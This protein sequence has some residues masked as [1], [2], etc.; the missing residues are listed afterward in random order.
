MNPGVL[1]YIG[2]FLVAIGVLVVVHELGHYCAA[3]L[4]NVKVLRFSVGF[5][6]TLFSR[7]LGP[8]QTEWSIAAFP[9]GGYVKMLDEGEAPVAEAEL[10]RAFNRQPVAKRA[11]IV[12]AGPLS[13]LLMAVA[14]YWV[15]HLIGIQEMRPLIGNPP[16]GSVAAEA[17]FL[18]GQLI[19]QVQG[20]SV[21]TWSDVRSEMLEP[22]LSHEP[23]EMIVG[24]GDATQRKVLPTSSL[25]EKDFESDLLERLGLTP[26][27][28][29]IRAVVGK[30]IDGSPAA[31]A[32]VV[33]GDEVVTIDDGPVDDWSSVVKAIQAGAGKTL[34]MEIQRSGVRVPL[35][36]S[37]EREAKSGVGRIGIAV[38]SDPA[39][40]A[41]LFVTVRHG[42]VDALI[43]SVAQTW[44]TVR[45][46]V[47]MMGRMVMGDISWHNI[48]GPITIADYAGQ[49]AK[50][51]LVPYLRFLA[52]ISISL[53]VLN[54][55]PVP[56]LDGGH[57]M[58]YLIEIVKGSPVSER[59]L[60][61][62]QRIGFSL[63]V[64]L[65][66]CALFND[67]NRLFSG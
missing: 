44:S 32:G 28:P 34:H 7:K 50:L 11:F 24:D 49:S 66:V 29:R 51:G 9:L 63:F 39:I 38:Q 58:Y 12:F 14:I 8:D 5:G 55:L 56:V 65:T 42:P 31:K 16:V 33:V 35:D 27:H 30:V 48:S 64:V 43:K 10:G 25:T 18:E 3:R 59:S 40:E 19:R 47:V 60:E 2:A 67:L 46:S 53:A 1:W 4:C 41:L 23:I 54:L 20:R 17:G 21:T 37:P 22:A 61:I 45:L 57:L 15:M 26:F 13:N 36:V 62:G 6:N 52:L